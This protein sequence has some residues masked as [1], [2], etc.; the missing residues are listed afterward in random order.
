MRLT[1]DLVK[2]STYTRRVHLAG[3]TLLC[4]LLVQYG[5]SAIVRQAAQLLDHAERVL[6]Y[7]CRVPPDHVHRIKIKW[8]RALT[9]ARLGS[10]SRAETL[11]KRVVEQLLAR[12]WNHDASQA[13]DALVWVIEQ[14]K[15]PG[16]A[17]FYV[18]KYTGKSQH[19]LAEK[20]K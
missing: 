13:L 5:T 10:L 16:R 17:S 7:R 9:L 6:I 1:S 8:G 18:W 14:T 15:M 20:K 4:A 19:H 2:A 12:G 3:V 11:L